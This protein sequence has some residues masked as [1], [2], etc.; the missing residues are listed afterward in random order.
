MAS[1]YSSSGKAGNCWV[2]KLRF[3]TDEKNERSFSKNELDTLENED[4]FDEPIE[5]VCAYKVPLNASQSAGIG[6][7]ASGLFHMFLVWK[8][9]NWYW[10]MEKH[11]DQITIQRNKD[12]RKVKGEFLGEPRNGNAEKIRETSGKG[13]KLKGMLNWLKSKLG[14][15]YN[16]FRSNCQHFVADVLE[17]F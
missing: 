16:V 9:K 12:E 10:S 13:K 14:E 7:T 3:V 11:T 1:S 4:G 5:E 6:S 8:T 17:F 2:S 15:A